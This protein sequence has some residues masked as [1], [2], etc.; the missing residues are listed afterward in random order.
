M[1]CACTTDAISEAC[2]YTAECLAGAASARAER[3][4]RELDGI[5]TPAEIRAAARLWVADLGSCDRC[6]ELLAD[7]FAA[8]AAIAMAMRLVRPRE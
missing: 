7:A 3:Y 8:R 1:P 4:V 5:P 2:R 6:H